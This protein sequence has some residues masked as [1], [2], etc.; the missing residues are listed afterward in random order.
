M[1]KRPER[2]RLERDSIGEL[3]VP[4]RAYYGIQT[5]RAAKNFPISGIRARPVF[6]TAT[7]MIKEAAARTNLS[8]GLLDRKRA[9]AIIRAASEI[10]SGLFHDEF[11]VDVY[12]AGAGTSHN[13]NANE[14]IANRAIELLGGRPGD[15]SVV[16]PNDHVNASQSTNDVIPASLRVAAIISSDRLVRSLKGLSGTF[17]KKAVAFD[18]IIK[19]GRTHLQDAVPIRL[20]QEFGGYASALESSVERLTGAVMRLKRI[21]LG[22]TATGTGMNTH[23]R[24]RKTVVRE[25]AAV[26]GLKG[27]RT[28]PD[29][30]A[31]ANSMGDFTA[32]SGALRDTA[33]ELTRIANDIRLLS[34]GPATGLAEITLPAVQPG[35]SIMPGK[36]NPV[37]AE[38]LD[39]AAFQVIGNDLAITLA[40]GAGQLEINVMTPLITHNLLQSIEILAN[41]TS[42]FDRR[43]VSGIKANASRCAAYFEGSTGLATALNTIIG[44]EA[45]AAIVK[46]A[47]QGNR[48]IKETVLDA[49]VMS[50]DEWTRLMQPRRITEPSLPERPAMRRKRRRKG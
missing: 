5:L 10:A 41:A 11:I 2:Q 44:Y 30:F 38:M 4:A 26:T 21:G 20:G 39:M 42:A 32:L 28:A 47:Q 7:A 15:Y 31:A 23:P 19:S 8:L 14:V 3:A 45:A 49:G 17:R 27:L 6:I 34:S 43:C 50:K 33:T 16:H 12:Q 9:K 18:G 1:S 29:Y 13:M 24:Y 40:A 25:L 35:S 22:G 37:M 48:S 46:K 36:V